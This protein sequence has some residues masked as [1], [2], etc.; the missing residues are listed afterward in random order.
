MV[1]LCFPIV[2]R[3]AYECFL[4]SH[5]ALSALFLYAVWRHLPPKQLLA[6]YCVYACAGAFTSTLCLQIATFFYRNGLFMSKGYPRAYIRC[7]IIPANA[8]KNKD[9]ENAVIVRVALPR[10]MK[11]DAGQYINL[12]MPTVSVFSWAQT[13]PFT[14]ISWSTETQSSLDLFIKP[15]KGLSATLY[16]RALKAPEGSVSFATFITGLHGISQPIDQYQTVLLLVNGPE[17][18]AALSYVRKL[19]R[20]YNTSFSRTRR[21]HLVWELKTLGKEIYNILRKC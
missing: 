3:L 9:V 21:I 2:R 8:D 13:H 11:L 19:I 20:G 10:P 7:G 18:A 14:V 4:K 5:Q 16:E 6:L 1:V 17:I 15:H 12:W